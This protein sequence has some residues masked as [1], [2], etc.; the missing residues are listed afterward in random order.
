MEKPDKPLE[1]LVPIILMEYI[2]LITAANCLL[3]ENAENETLFKISPDVYEKI[4]SEPLK[5]PLIGIIMNY[6][7]ADGILKAKADEGLNRIYANKIMREVALQYKENYGKR[8]TGFI[9]E[10][11]N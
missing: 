1:L 7:A 8:Y 9:S 2:R 3:T 5:S 11:T 4:M 6:N 10:I